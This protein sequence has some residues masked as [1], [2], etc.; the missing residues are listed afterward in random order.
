M[1][2]SITNNSV[3]DGVLASSTL[4]FVFEDSTF[5]QL[6]ATP[7]YFYSMELPEAFQR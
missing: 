1:E 6:F 7:L 4:L 5:N 3:D 2:S